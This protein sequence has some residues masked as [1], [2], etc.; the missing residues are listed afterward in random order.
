[1]PRIAEVPNVAPMTW[2]E[3]HER[4]RIIREVE[5][6]ATAD[7]SG[8]LPWREE[9]AALFGDRDGLLMALRS[10]WDRTCQ[11]QLD[12]RLSDVTLDETY[13]QLRKRHA[14]VLRILERYA[15]ARTSVPAGA[16][17]HAS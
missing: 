2:T 6:A 3:T 13:R 17:T 7:P 12:S 11:A 14:G 5:A 10:R 8:A 1:M 9:Y 16:V 15:G 4:H